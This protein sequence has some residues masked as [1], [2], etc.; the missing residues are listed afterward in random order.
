MDMA[1]W[2]QILDES[3]S[4]WNSGTSLKNGI[5]SIILPPAMDK[6]SNRLGSLS[7]I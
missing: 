1:N 5:N 3:E 4:I 6:Y 2:V 7:L